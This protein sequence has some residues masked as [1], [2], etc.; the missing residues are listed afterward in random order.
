[1]QAPSRPLKESRDDTIERAAGTGL[2]GHSDQ[3][4]VPI[5]LGPLEA[6]ATIIRLRLVIGSESAL[7]QNAEPSVVERAAPSRP[8]PRP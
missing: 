6:E 3:R 5:Q 1:V 8:A 2:T 7:A 4:F